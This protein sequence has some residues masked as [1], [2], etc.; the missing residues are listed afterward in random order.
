MIRKALLIALACLF[1]LGLHAQQM[2]RPVDGLRSPEDAFAFIK[3]LSQRKFYDE[4]I[5]QTKAFQET[6]PGHPLTE[7]VEA[8]RIQALYAEKQYSETA[9]AIRVHLEKFPK[10]ENRAEFLWT[11]GDCHF[12]LK[13]YE[14]AIPAYEAVLNEKKGRNLEES[15]YYLAVCLESLGRSE[16]AKGHLRQLAALPSDNEH[17]P[18]VYARQY[19]AVLAQ[20]EGN[21]SGALAIYKPLLLLKALPAQLRRNLLL[22]AGALAFLPPVQDYSQAAEIYGAFVIEFP[23]DPQ[24]RLIRRSLLTCLFFQEKYDE[25]LSAREDYQKRFPGTEQDWELDWL[26]A[27]AYVQKEHYDQA[28]PILQRI[29][30]DVQ[31]PSTLKQ[32]AMQYVVMCLDKTRQDEALVVAAKKYC[33]DYPAA[34]DGNDILCMAAEAEWR[35][36]RLPEAIADFTRLL[37]LLAAGDPV[38]YQK[39]G[40]CLATLLDK[41]EQ[42]SQAAALFLELADKAPETS[43][44]ANFHAKREL[45]LYAVT[46]L[47]RL[48][49]DSR[50]LP[51][52]D[53]LIQTATNDEEK[54]Q[55]LQ[56]KYQF[57]MQDN[58]PEVSLNAI[59]DILTLTTPARQPTWL[60]LRAQLHYQVKDYAQTIADYQKLM[61][62]PETSLDYRRQVLPELVTLLYF[63]KAETTMTPLLKE[64]FGLAPAPTLSEPLLITIARDCTRHADWQNARL[65]YQRILSNPS[66]AETSVDLY[67]FLL[68]DVEFRDGKLPQAKELLQKSADAR[69]R[70]G[71]PATGDVAAMLAEIALQEGQPDVALIY[72]KQALASTERFGSKDTL[73]RAQWALAQ[74]LLA[75]KDDAGAFTAAS[76]G[77]IM[78]KHPVYSPRCLLIAAQAKEHQGDTKTAQELRKN[79]QE[80]YPDF[81]QQ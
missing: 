63:T 60:L 54:I 59:E 36:N 53:S 1:S 71:L 30:E 42:P 41:T 73:P 18:R 19:L 69:G 74:A 50:R 58:A 44:Q 68:A 29:T 26:T 57:G 13:E 11:Q 14:K 56:Y 32:P 23:D 33:A 7:S 77:F 40:C 64:L 24:I 37:P 28:L 6:Y 47:Y 70:R 51:L 75:L 9:E 38:K 31:A 10:S 2:D 49:G 55:L 46:P 4:V 66:L 27:Q 81:Y 5:R 62:H 79:L 12:R 15:R 25:F 39:V 22:S 16:E 78:E 34:L 20:N 61:A 48:P 45:Q 8:W 21:S 76:R 80:E 17:L 65:A 67:L 35:L 52:L 3:G 72:A 43:E